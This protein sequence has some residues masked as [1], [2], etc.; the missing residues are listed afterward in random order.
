MAVVLLKLRSFSANISEV[1]KCFKSF[2][3]FE[4]PNNRILGERTAQFSYCLTL[5]LNKLRV[6]WNGCHSGTT[7]SHISRAFF[8][9]EVFQF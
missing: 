2:L 1:Y 9:E 7:F 6:D 3:I 4:I 8:V 5:T